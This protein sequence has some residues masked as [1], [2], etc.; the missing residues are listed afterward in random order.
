MENIYMILTTHELNYSAMDMRTL[1]VYPEHR[2]RL[3]NGY[4]EI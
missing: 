4:N 1:C 2:T 3:E